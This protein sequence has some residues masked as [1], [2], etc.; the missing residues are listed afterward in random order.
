MG[1]LLWWMLHPPAPVPAAVA[2]ARH[3]VNALKRILV[4][5]VGEPYAEH[6]VELACRL[7]QEQGAEIF[8]V[9]VLEVPRTLPLGVRLPL[10]ESKAEEALKR[11]QEIVSLHGLPSSAR[12][13]RAREAA[14]GILRVI[15][16]HDVDLVVLGIRP[17]LGGGQE[18]LGKTALDLLRH[19]PC[20][21]VIDKP[22]R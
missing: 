11:A 3:S 4:P 22:P 12:I 19:A 6:G 10:D 2:K 21:V 5:T 16:E 15:R 9:Y 14:G 8:L 18:I 20:E 17:S 7:G 13:E 1:G